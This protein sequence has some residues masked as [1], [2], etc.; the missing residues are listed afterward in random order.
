MLLK[1]SDNL[2]VPARACLKQA[3]NKPTGAN[4]QLHYTVN[5]PKIISPDSRL[6][7]SFKSQFE[8]LVEM[9]IA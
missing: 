4:L 6:P 7:P 3:Q 2:V 1:S 9:Y 5:L 8:P